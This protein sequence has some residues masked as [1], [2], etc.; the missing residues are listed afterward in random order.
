MA[1]EI[2]GDLT[3]EEVRRLQEVA[4][5]DT[6]TR[7][8]QRAMVVL[9]SQT[10]ESQATL[11]KALGV[12]RSFV[13]AARKRW[14]R[15]GIGGLYDAPRSGRPSKTRGRF[16]TLLLQTVKRSPR[17]M[18][19]AFQRWTCPRLAEYMAQRTGIRVTEV[20]I[21]ELLHTQ[22]YVWR[23]TQRSLRDLQDR[24][25]K[26]HAHQRLTRLKKGRNI[27]KQTT[28]SGSWMK[29]SSTCIPMSHTFGGPVVP[30]TA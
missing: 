16:M 22:G 8:R 15:E 6:S 11:S 10:G 23:R 9:L 18:G 17:D 30:D 14:R 27:P 20:W 25:Q 5:W 13:V 2:I 1:P 7:P 12:S 4:K 19:F 21:A 26:E 28:N 29:R 24:K 3:S